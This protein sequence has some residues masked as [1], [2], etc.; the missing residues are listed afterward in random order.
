MYTHHHYLLSILASHNTPKTHEHA[1][2]L[3]P[4][5]YDKIPVIVKAISNNI[6]NAITPHVATFDPIQYYYPTTYIHLLQLL[7]LTGFYSPAHKLNLFE[8]NKSSNISPTD[9]VQKNLDIAYGFYSE[10][11]H[12]LSPLINNDEPHN[13]RQAILSLLNRFLFDISYH[14]P[15]TL[16]S[17]PTCP[18]NT[19]TLSIVQKLA[20]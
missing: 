16:N 20:R 7:A 17:N 9:S 19:L 15:D 14:Y 13:L 1:L 11:A 6:S 4:Q 8:H 5:D 12:V 10:F 18:F 3:S 2:R